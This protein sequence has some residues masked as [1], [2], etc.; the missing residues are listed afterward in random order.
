M[1]DIDDEDSQDATWHKNYMTTLPDGK[2]SVHSMTNDDEDKGYPTEDAEWT[3][4]YPNLEAAK[5]IVGVSRTGFNGCKVE[6]FLD[7]ERI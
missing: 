4:T 2:I 5:K 6:V 7:G 3:L 1:S